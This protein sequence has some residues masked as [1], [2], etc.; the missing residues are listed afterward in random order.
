MSTMPETHNFEDRANVNHNESNGEP[1]LF[2]ALAVELTVA[3][4]RSDH[5]YLI[6]GGS[7]DHAG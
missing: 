1:D 7:H 6:C 4:L 3:S 2:N 5:I